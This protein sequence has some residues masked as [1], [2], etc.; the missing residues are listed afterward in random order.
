MVDVEAF[1]AWDFQTAVVETHQ[2]QDGGV[3]VGGNVPFTED[4]VFTIGRG[5]IKVIYIVG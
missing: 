4:V 5:Y 2:V 1:A 3:Q